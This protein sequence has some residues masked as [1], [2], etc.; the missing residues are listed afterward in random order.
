MW[1]ELECRVEAELNSSFNVFLAQ[2][3]RFFSP[4]SK[5]IQ[6]IGFEK[7][8]GSYCLNI[9]MLK[10]CFVKQI[11]IAVATQRFAVSS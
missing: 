4:I 8:A 5:G 11:N 3:C 7:T 1:L 9:K 10:F 2:E 6:F